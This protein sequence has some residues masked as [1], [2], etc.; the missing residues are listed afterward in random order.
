MSKFLKIM[1]VLLTIVAV[2]TPVVAEDRL[3]LSGQMRVRGWHVDNGGDDTESWMD[4]RLRI[5]GKFSIA[6]GVSVTFRT[7]L[8]ES[9]WGSG[10]AF[11]SGRTAPADG[12]DFQA[13]HVDRAHLDIASGNLHLRAGQQY[14]AFGSNGFDAQSNGITLN[15]KGNIPV[16]LFWML[17][18]DGGSRTAA[19]DYYYGARVAHKGEKY[20]SQ[21]F[22]AGQK[23]PH[24]DEDVIVVGATLDYDLEPVALYA[25]VEFFTGDANATQDAA[26]TQIY[27]SADMAA[28]ETVNVGG[29]LFYSMGD[30]EDVIYN[31]LGNDFGGWDPLF[32]LGTGLDN[33]KIGAGRPFDF[34]GNAGAI[35]VQLNASA[36]AT[37]DLNVAAAVAFVQSED[38][39]IIDDE[40]TALALGLSYAVMANT[41]LGVQVEYIDVDS[42]DDERLQVGTGLFVNF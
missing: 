27:V 42:E 8:T 17:N 34:F 21:L 41:K 2:A 36:Q 10:N 13:I 11:G 9:D 16:T 6:E 38:D 32:A 19:D 1:I 28:S 20:A 30:D 39:D 29:K 33:E 4:Q 22:V 40:A 31:L 14:L 7:D 15:V 26:G 18:E 3:G 12:S 23:A 25:E 35:A 24:A 37:D 5:G